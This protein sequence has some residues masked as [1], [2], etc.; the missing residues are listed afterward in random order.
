M[1]ISIVGSGYVGLGTA[2]GFMGNG[3]RVKCIDTDQ[4]KVNM[5]NNG[6][7]P[8]YEGCHQARVYS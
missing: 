8:I 6:Q 4:S 1:D 5:I 3:H 2:I 7:S